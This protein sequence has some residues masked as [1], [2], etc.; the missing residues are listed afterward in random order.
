MWGVRHHY[1]KND[2]VVDNEFPWNE[3]LHRAIS[4]TICIERE[5]NWCFKQPISSKTFP[6]LVK[7]VAQSI[8]VDYGGWQCTGQS[9]SSLFTSIFIIATFATYAIMSSIKTT[10]YK[11]FYNLSPT[12]RYLPTL[13]IQCSLWAPMKR[14]W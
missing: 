9:S 6:I 3:C 5:W 13:T 7:G 4:W 12:V 1:H 11:F 10:S 2:N 14:T 8:K